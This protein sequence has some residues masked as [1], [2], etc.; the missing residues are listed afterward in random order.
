VDAQKRMYRLRAEPL[1]ELDAWV[2]PYRRHWARHLDALEK[3]LAT[4]EDE[5]SAEGAPRGKTDARG[6][7][8]VPKKK[9]K[10]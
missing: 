1:R 10:R 6:A 2:A 5:R 9:A 4:M 3:H 8:H 7:V